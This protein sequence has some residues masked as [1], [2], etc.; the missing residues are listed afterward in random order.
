MALSHAL[1][2]ASLEGSQLYGLYISN[3][4]TSD[5]ELEAIQANFELCCENANTPGQIAVEIGSTAKL[6]TE[7][8]RWADLVITSKK[9]KSLEE[10]R[11]LIQSC[12]TPILVVNQGNL[13]FKRALLAYDGSPK[14]EEALFLAAYLTT[15]WELSLMV[16][17][18]TETSHMQKPSE[19]FVHAKEYLDQYGVPASLL[20]TD[21]EPGDSILQATEE[22]SSDV[23]ILGGY[24]D[25][26]KGDLWCELLDQILTDSQQ[27]ILICV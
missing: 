15:F 3:E 19:T 2:I 25:H 27:A 12:P 18:V 22:Q 24:C 13:P 20:E 4:K 14:S 11:M 21:H 8:A 26:I 17:T 10:F 7:R 9:G 6:I 5:D 16:M 23:I 1:E